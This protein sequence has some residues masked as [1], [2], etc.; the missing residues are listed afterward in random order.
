[1]RWFSRKADRK[2]ELHTADEVGILADGE[3]VRKVSGRRGRAANAGC[4]GMGKS[5]K[6][7]GEDGES[8][9]RNVLGQSKTQVGVG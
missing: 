8:H 5:E 9:G 2:N 7:D 6:G 3:Q 1:M 4:D